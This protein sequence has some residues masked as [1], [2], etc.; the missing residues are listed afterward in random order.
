MKR[1]EF[2]AVA[3]LLLTVILT[4]VALAETQ[5]RRYDRV[6]TYDPVK[7]DEPGRVNNWLAMELKLTPKEKD[8]IIPQIRKII[9]L[10][11]KAAPGLRRLKA[12]QQDKNASAEKI[13]AGLK[14]FR[15]NL[16]DAR[17]RIIR[18]YVQFDDQ[19]KLQGFF[20]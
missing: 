6:P 4:T 2:I 19:A 10:K 9:T 3:V 8:V 18:A 16:A 1:I 17:G 5:Y 7:R 12:L 15:N 20:P 14:R 13:A 11:R